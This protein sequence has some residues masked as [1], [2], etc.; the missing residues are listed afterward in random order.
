MDKFKSLIPV[1][2]ALILIPA[3]L[4]GIFLIRSKAPQTIQ[5]KAADVAFSLSF[6][7]KVLTGIEKDSEFNADL[8]LFTT[9]RL[10]SGVDVEIKYPDSLK[11]LDFKPDTSSSGLEVAVIP[12]TPDNFSNTLR[13][14]GVNKSGNLP[15]RQTLKLGTIKFKAVKDNFSARVEINKAQ[16]IIPGENK[17]IDPDLETGEYTSSSSPAP[18]ISSPPG[19]SPSAASTLS[20]INGAVKGNSCVSNIDFVEWFKEWSGLSQSKNADF[21]P[22]CKANNTRGDGIIDIADFEVWR[23]EI[24]GP[25]KCP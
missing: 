25:N 1:I 19:S 2:V 21:F 20:C 11:V 18:S 4:I 17:S 5:S 24:S 8:I 9:G 23:R 7:P 15:L 16:V 10:I 13:Y 6:S 14:V 3:I 22:E 12:A